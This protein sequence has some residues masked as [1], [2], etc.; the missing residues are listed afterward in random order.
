MRVSHIVRFDALIAYITL[1][2]AKPRDLFNILQA[3]IKAHSSPTQPKAKTNKQNV[4]NC[5]YHMRNIKFITFS[6]RFSCIVCVCSR[7][8][9]NKL[10]TE[11]CLC[12]Y[13]VDVYESLC[14]SI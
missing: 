13:I 3:V 7:T 6:V 8:R 12:E 14:S 5:N 1:F 9:A 10:A 11:H 2:S 4:C